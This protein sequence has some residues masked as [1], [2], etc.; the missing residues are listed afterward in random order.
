MKKQ[1]ALRN[2]ENPNNFDTLQFPIKKERER[3]EWPKEEE[4]KEGEKQKV[5]KVA[6]IPNSASPDWKYIEDEGYI[7]EVAVINE[8]SKRRR[9]LDPTATWFVN[10]Y[11]NLL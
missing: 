1:K 11:R 9:R 5:V 4:K 8:G 2:S 6:S 7:T 10:L 3:R